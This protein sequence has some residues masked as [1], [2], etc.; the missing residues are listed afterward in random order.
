MVDERT[1][2]NP[3]A[4]SELASSQKD[5]LTEFDSTGTGRGQPGHKVRVSEGNCEPSESPGLPSKAK[6]SL[7]HIPRIYNSWEHLFQEEATAE[8]LP[9]HQSWDH[10]IRLEPGKQPTFGPIYA[11][12]EKELEVLRGYLAENEKKG[13]IR[14]SQS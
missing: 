5:D 13:F 10:E 3:T 8:A 11:L 14:K 2:R 12:S 4:S 7:K 9:K 6:E 1:S